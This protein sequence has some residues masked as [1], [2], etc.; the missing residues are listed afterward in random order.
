MFIDFRQIVS[1]QCVRK[2]VQ[3]VSNIPNVTNANIMEASTA[4]GVAEGIPSGGESLF[5]WSV[6]ATQVGQAGQGPV[7]IHVSLDGSEVFGPARHSRRK[8]SHSSGLVGPNSRK[9]NRGV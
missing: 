3:N 8:S 1:K 9:L 4:G 5:P 2:Y 6:A 7:S